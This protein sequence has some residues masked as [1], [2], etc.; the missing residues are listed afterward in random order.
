MLRL[1]RLA[2][3]A[4]GSSFGKKGLGGRW[5]GGQDRPVNGEKGANLTERGSRAES[6]C[7]RDTAPLVLMGS[8]RICDPTRHPGKYQDDR[9]RLSG[10]LR[11]SDP[12]EPARRGRD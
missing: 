11:P 12:F 8:I 7:V 1:R 2:D 4:V 6:A 5:S 3:M 10:G 9:L